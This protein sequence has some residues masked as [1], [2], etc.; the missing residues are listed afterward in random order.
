MEGDFHHHIVCFYRLQQPAGEYRVLWATSPV[1][2]DPANANYMTSYNVVAVGSDNPRCI[3]QA[4][5][6]HPTDVVALLGSGVTGWAVQLV[7]LANYPP[8]HHRGNLH[9]ELGIS[10]IIVFNTTT[11]VFRLMSSPAQLRAQELLLV[12]MDGALAFCSFSTNRDTLDVWVM[13]DYDAE[14]WAFKHRINLS[15]VDTTSRWDSRM[16][17]YAKMAV[18]NGC[19]LLIQFSLGHV[20]HYDSHGKFLGYVKSEEDRKMYLWVTTH[21]LQESVL[22]LPLIHEMREEDAASKEPPSF[23][24]L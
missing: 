6:P 1:Y 15:V 11:E 16:T 20:L 14:I 18:L 7:Q 8:V 12:E 21:Y 2:I 17:M 24:G 9:W 19:E 22:P 3:R 13:Q 5:I 23:V 4:C 10:C